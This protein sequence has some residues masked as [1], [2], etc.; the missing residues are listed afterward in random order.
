MTCCTIS[1]GTPTRLADHIKQITDKI[2]SPNKLPSQSSSSAILMTSGSSLHPS[3]AHIIPVHAAAVHS[4]SGHRIPSH[5]QILIRKQGLLSSFLTFPKQIP[6]GLRAALPLLGI[7]PLAHS[8]SAS[9]AAAHVPPPLRTSLTA[10]LVPAESVFRP[11]FTQLPLNHPPHHHHDRPLGMPFLHFPSPVSQM[12]SNRPGATTSYL[13]PPFLGELPQQPQ[14]QTAQQQAHLIAAHA[15]NQA[16]N[17]I[18]ATAESAVE[19]L[20]ISESFVSAL[21]HQDNSAVATA[22]SG[23]GPVR[24]QIQFVPLPSSPSQEH[25]QHHAYTFTSDGGVQQ[26][27]SIPIT[28]TGGAASPINENRPVDDSGSSLNGDEAEKVMYVYVDEEGKTIATKVADMDASPDSGLPAGYNIKAVGAPLPVS[29]QDQENANQAQQLQQQHNQQQNSQSGESS[30]PKA[31]RPVLAGFAPLHEI[32]AVAAAQNSP[33]DP[34]AGSYLSSSISPQ[35]HQTGVGSANNNNNNNAGPVSSDPEPNTESPISMGP[36]AAASFA[37]RF[38]FP[39]QQHHHQ[40]THDNQQQQQHHQQDQHQQ[41]QHESKPV[42]LDEESIPI[43][44]HPI[45]DPEVPHSDPSQDMIFMLGDYNQYLKSQSGVSEDEGRDAADA[46]NDFLHALT[47]EKQVPTNVPV[48]HHSTTN[49]NQQQHHQSTGS[50]HRPPIRKYPR[51]LTTHGGWIPISRAP[52]NTAS[53]NDRKITIAILSPK[54]QGKEVGATSQNQPEEKK[55][56]TSESVGHQVPATGQEDSSSGSQNTSSSGTNTQ[57]NTETTDKNVSEPKVH[58]DDESTSNL[59]DQAAG[60]HQSTR[61]SY[62]TSSTVSVSSNDEKKTEGTSADDAKSEDDADEPDDLKKLQP[63]VQKRSKYN[64]AAVFDHE[65]KPIYQ[66][67]KSVD[68]VRDQDLI[69]KSFPRGL[70]GMRIPR[71]SQ[72]SPSS[73]DSND[74]MTESS[75]RVESV[76]VPTKNSDFSLRSDRKFNQNSLQ[77]PSGHFIL[78]VPSGDGKVKAYIVLSDSGTTRPAKLL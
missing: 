62:S 27:Q 54:D 50:L 76:Y 55:Q 43:T 69:T 18:P 19:S 72:S 75:D 30:E 2:L 58:F 59:Q 66:V 40:L 1:S 74:Q 6:K 31:Q 71:S 70:Y 8:V 10:H 21:H 39:S 73:L 42:V 11:Q 29:Q 34:D 49:N 13:I 36:D 77:E 20:G 45:V 9:V 23:H 60:A 33:P 46:A 63:S 7:R 52:D 48:I 14:Q 3:I 44:D 12:G 41:E 61:I 25:Q 5:H 24:Q 57:S 67:S 68:Q 26:M 32:T 78:P 51:I 4:S 64:V 16:G 65:F 47:S 53:V 28:T 35:M 56:Q 17:F 15:S 22:L 38:L 37:G